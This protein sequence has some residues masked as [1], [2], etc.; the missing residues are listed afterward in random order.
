MNSFIEEYREHCVKYKFLDNEKVIKN[1]DTI[2]YKENITNLVV[3]YKGEIEEDFI[4][5]IINFIK[6]RCGA[7]KVNKC[8]CVIFINI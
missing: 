6:R 2:V 5:E 4:E 3:T 7:S 8:E 1:G